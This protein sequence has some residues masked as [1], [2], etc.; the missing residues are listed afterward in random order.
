MI[1][2]ASYKTDIPAFYGEWFLHRLREGYCK[3]L[4]HYNRQVTR[5]S[6]MRDD[7]DGFVF[8]TRNIG[9]FQD[10]LAEVNRLGYPFMIQHTI[11]DYPKKLERA[12]IP[13]A[14]AIENVH[15]V[16]DLYG[17]RICVWRYDPI[18]ES[19]LTPR[20]HHL[21]T[22]AR[23]A[24]TLE[25][26]VD[27]VAI[28]FIRLYQKTTRNLRMVGDEDSFSYVESTKEWKQELIQDLSSIAS[29]HGI[30]L[31][32]C[33]HPDL[34]DSCCQEARCVDAERLRDIGGERFNANRRGTRK[35][36]ACFESRDIGEY[37]TCPH[38]CVYCYAVKDRPL[39]LERYREHDPLAEMLFE[40]PSTST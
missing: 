34:L 4:N 28:S 19:T 33:S 24:K 8:W 1:I 9:G 35:E 18:I 30:R 11:N 36:C 12:V 5:I 23:L 32:L 38:G 13:A 40:L 31:S 17:P 14:R 7:V 39:A 6:L 29:S 21:A 10:A 37:D 27:E 22:F 26:A 3:T 25:G 16:A 2:S 15:R 20:D